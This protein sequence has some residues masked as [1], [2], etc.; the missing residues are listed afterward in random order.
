AKNI[1][2]L[3]E[4]AKDINYPVFI[5]GETERENI[6]PVPSN[7]TFLGK[8]TREEIAA[9]LS[10]AWIYALPVKYE[11]FGYTFLEAAFSGC[12]LVGG[13]IPSL[14][15]VWND[16]MV[17][18]P[19]TDSSRLAELVNGLMENDRQLN[20]LSEKAVA[21]ASRKYRLER[22][23]KEYYYLYRKVERF[24]SKILLH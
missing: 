12:V 14:H 11:P 9:W 22:M 15:E 7:V 16:A 10:E 19:T 4:A 24:K 3:I 6:G 18:T 13:D 5:A 23:V 8:L 21:V 17:Y 1:K 20:E 2:L